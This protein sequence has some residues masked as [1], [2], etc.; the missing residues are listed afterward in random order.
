MI[1]KFIHIFDKDNIKN[2]Y[3]ILSI[4]LE[5]VIC[6]TEQQSTNCSMIETEGTLNPSNIIS[7]NKV[8]A[9]IGNVDANNNGK[10]IFSSNDLYKAV[11][12]AGYLK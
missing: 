5:K 3:P 10:Q 2:N 7:W 8:F 6:I 4:N 11:K 12:L 9:V 1:A